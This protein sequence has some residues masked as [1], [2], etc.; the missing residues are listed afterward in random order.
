[1]IY[2]VQQNGNYHNFRLGGYLEHES[3]RTVMEDIHERY[4]E[5]KYARIVF[6]L[7]HL[8]FVGSVSITSFVSQ[9]NEF[10]GKNF[11]PLYYGLKSEFLRMFRMIEKEEAFLIFSQKQEAI[12]YAEQMYRDPMNMGAL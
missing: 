10:N 7:T 12:S 8:E 2:R 6:D 3:V 4:Q 11:R 1:M 5:N 9:L